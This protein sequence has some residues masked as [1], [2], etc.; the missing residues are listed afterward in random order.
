MVSGRGLGW[1]ASILLSALLA[2]SPSAY[3]QSFS[4]AGAITINDN[5]AATPYPSN[6]AVALD[7][8]AIVTN[9]TVT[10]TG[11]NHTFPDD[12]DILLVGPTLQTLLLMSDTGGATDAVGVTLTFDDAAAPS[13]PDGSPLVAGTFKPTDIGAGDAFPAP[14]PAAPYGTTLAAFNGTNANGTWS[15]YV[16]DDAGADLG[17]ITGGWTLNLVVVIPPVLVLN[18][19]AVAVPAGPT[20]GTTVNSGATALSV[21]GGSGTVALVAITRNTGATVDFTLPA[22]GN[23]TT[24]TTNAL[25]AGGTQS[26]LG[27]Y[28]TVG[29]TTWAVSGIAGGPF[30]ITG[31]ATGSYSTTF[32]TATDVDAPIGASAPAS[33]LTINSLRLN[34]AGAY[35]INLAGPLTLATGGILETAA[36]GANAAAINNSTLSSGN[37][38]DLVVIQNNTAGDLTINSQIIGATGLTKSGTGTLILGNGANTYAGTTTVNQG[39]L[40]ITGVVAAPVTVGANGTLGGTGT[41]GSTTVNGT[42]A[43]GASAGTLTISGSYTQNAG[44]TYQAELG[45]PSDLLAVTGAATIN[46]GTVDARRATGF[47]VGTYTILNAAGGRAGTYGAL[48]NNLGGFYSPTLVYGANTVQIQVA[49]NF[50]SLANSGATQNQL[51]LATLL[52]RLSGAPSADFGNVIDGLA[53]LSAGGVR[54]A[55]DQL[56]NSENGNTIPTALWIG[57]LFAES[58][59]EQTRAALGMSPFAISGLDPTSQDSLM[60]YPPPPLPGERRKPAARTAAADVPPAAERPAQAPPV[61]AWISGFG[62]GSEIDGNS[63]ARASDSRIGGL[64]AGFGYN[65]SREGVIG[66]AVGAAFSSIRGEGI[67][68][69]AELDTWSLGLYGGHTFGPAY[70]NAYAGYTH[71]DIDTTRTLLFGAIDRTAEGNHEGRQV[72]TNFEAGWRLGGEEF[73]ATPFAGLMYSW[74]DEDG[75]TETGAD[76]LNLDVDGH[77]S[78]SLRTGVGARMAFATSVGTGTFTPEVG[79]RWEHEL[80]D[81]DYDT[82]ARFAALSDSGFFMRGLDRPRDAVVLT[83]GLAIKISEALRTFVGAAARLGP[84]EDTYMGR[85]GVEV[86][87]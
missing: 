82:Q 12:I 67:A 47:R 13:L 79:A 66:L 84:V 85:G 52:D 28:A 38:Q 87:W 20:G 57:R 16:F 71:H 77:T 60:V 54:D 6:I 65:F 58:I 41:V 32:T 34:N 23:F 7:P 18:G 63:E 68:G 76:S 2:S 33:G 31:L 50:S 55:L 4:N 22:P 26:I 45:T 8:A 56:D 25:F 44:S 64:S 11:I 51:A 30:N 46:G 70:A 49:T 74:L 53:G 3:A 1:S 35:T 48:T 43:P 59:G 21:A 37:G 36:V 40:R 29:G 61:S 14:A 10:L 81:D 15:L 19:G 75:Y 39:V 24:T 5:A 80:L 17:T 42:I 9:A 86:R 73:S 69:D 78:Q 27:G 72:D 62:A 83:L